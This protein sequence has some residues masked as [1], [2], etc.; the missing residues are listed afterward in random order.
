MYIRFRESAHRY[1]PLY[2]LQSLLL[3][4]SKCIRMEKLFLVKDHNSKEKPTLGSSLAYWLCI[5]IVEV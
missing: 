3:L 1:T 4:I 5:L 2:I